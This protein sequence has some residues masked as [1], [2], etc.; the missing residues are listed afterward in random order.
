MALFLSGQS[1]AGVQVSLRTP[2]HES[3]VSHILTRVKRL[4]QKSALSI[5]QC[6]EEPRLLGG[7]HWDDGG[8]EQKSTIL[9]R[10]SLARPTPASLAAF[11]NPAVVLMALSVPPAAHSGG[12]P[13]SGSE[14]AAESDT[15]NE[16]FA[17]TNLEQHRNASV[18]VLQ[19]QVI[20]TRIT[21][22]LACGA[23]TWRGGA[24]Y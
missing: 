24:L 2:S 17:H 8:Q 13:D 21:L 12:R 16:R 19:Q 7:R 18:Q 15:I 4:N 14:L 5:C 6:E 20:R 1:P 10:H 23:T 11:G 9:P 3:G 22:M